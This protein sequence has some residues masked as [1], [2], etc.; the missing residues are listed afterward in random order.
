MKFRLLSARGTGL[1]QLNSFQKWYACY[2]AIS[3]IKATAYRFAR[4]R[5]RNLKMLHFAKHKQSEKNAWKPSPF[6]FQKSEYL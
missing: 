1:A 4:L 6:F 2:N 5:K 3:P